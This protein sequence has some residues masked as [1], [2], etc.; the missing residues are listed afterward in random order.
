[1]PIS[2]KPVLVVDDEVLIRDCVQK[3]LES[4][5][6]WKVLR[7]DTGITGLATAKEEQPDVILL[8]VSMP[9]MDGIRTL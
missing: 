2:N 7:A 3:G 5:R 1:M 9:E 8:D 4:L 6:G